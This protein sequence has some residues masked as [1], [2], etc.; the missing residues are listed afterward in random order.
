MT[1]ETISFEGFDCVRLDGDASA[2]LVTVSAG[3]RVL[4]LIGRAGNL[5]AVLPDAELEGPEGLRFR[6]IGGHRLWAA[7]EIPTVTYQPDERACSFA[8]VEA[9]VRVESPA[10]GAGLV[11]TI[12]V[13][14]APGGW[15]VDHEIRNVSSGPIEVAAWGVTQLRPG[16]EARLSIG[17]GGSGLQADRSLVLWPYTDLADERLCFERDLVRVRAPRSGTPLKIGAA[18]GGSWLAYGVGSEIFEKRIEPDPGATYPDRGAS[19]Q[20][21][22]CEAFCELET[23]GPLQHLR[24]GDRTRHRE[25]WTLTE[26]AADPA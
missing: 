23:L 24:P 15:V 16:G 2:V 11:K 18:P 21:Y 8:E 10:D 7:P 14:R 25:R 20:V 6:F 5:M 12:E 3:P 4:G 13:C 1:L 19:V 26:R 9:G 22:V 17:D